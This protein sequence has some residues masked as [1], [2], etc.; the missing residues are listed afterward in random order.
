MAVGAGIGALVGKARDRGISDD[1]IKQAGEAIETSGAVVF[2]LADQANS[3]VITKLIDEA[4]AGGAKV[5]YQVLSEDAQD[6]L[7]VQLKTGGKVAVGVQVEFKGMTL[8]QYDEVVKRMGFEPR[9]PGG[10][11]ALFHW[12][13]KTS[14]GIRATDVWE[15]QEDFE[16]FP[17]EKIGPITQEVGIQS[18]PEIQHFNVH[19][20][21][22]AG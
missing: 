2:V 11:G 10:P 14:D 21:L 18:Q 6:L 16:K 15:N 13:T 22:T 19:N 7:R 12:V 17:E 3:Q 1:L 5:E 9:G 20:Y 8:E 4:V